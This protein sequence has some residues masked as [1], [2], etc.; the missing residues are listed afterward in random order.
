MLT[1][2][3][4]FKGTEWTNLETAIEVIGDM[5]AYKSSLLHAAL[6][7]EKVDSQMISSLETEISH[8]GKERQA[9]YNSE[10]N[11]EIIIKAYTVYGPQLNALGNNK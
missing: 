9:C 6:K 7:A 11:Q 3:K 10:T 1:T 5:I 4:V 2:E 8:L